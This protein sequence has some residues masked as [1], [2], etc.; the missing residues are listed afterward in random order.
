[1]SPVM[2]KG[3]D[4]KKEEGR[5]GHTTGER[6]IVSETEEGSGSRHHL[7]RMKGW[8]DWR[9]EATVRPENRE[10]PEWWGNIEKEPSSRK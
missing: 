1:M 5:G 10:M 9:G 8:V 7:S 4:E 6:N 3:K 2:T